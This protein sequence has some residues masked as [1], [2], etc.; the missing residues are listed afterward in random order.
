MTSTVRILVCILAQHVFAMPVPE[1]SKQ[2]LQKAE[3]LTKERMR[4]GKTDEN[5]EKVIKAAQSEEKK[6]D[7]E[8][9]DEE[10][11]RAAIDAEFDKVTDRA[12]TKLESEKE[13]FEKRTDSDLEAFEQHEESI[14]EKFK[15]REEA[16]MDKFEK[17]L[18]PDEDVHA[19]H[20]SSF[21]ET[22]RGREDGEPARH[23][24]FDLSGVKKRLL[25]ISETAEDIAKKEHIEKTREHDR[26]LGFDEKLSEFN[27][28]M[29]TRLAKDESDFESKI[30]SGV[31]STAKK[32]EENFDAFKAAEEHDGDLFKKAMDTGSN[33]ESTMHLHTPSS[34]LQAKKTYHLRK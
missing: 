27:D 23:N 13:K 20:A 29:N 19:K 32:N 16:D 11:K 10:K 26:F 9:E 24:V 25:E 21:M 5:L 22:G 3:E 18:L 2:E 31:D 1:V 34:F 15:E 8:E 14:G 4:E 6:L 33:E 28:K 12:Q 30:Q 7:H 17:A